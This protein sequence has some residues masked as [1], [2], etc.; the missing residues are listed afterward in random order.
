MDLMPVSAADHLPV[1][2][3][4]SRG[5]GICPKHGYIRGL[6]VLPLVRGCNR[7]R[8]GDE[9]GDRAGVE[10]GIKTEI[11]IESRWG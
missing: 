4:C 11:R 1:T 9:T 8:D 3:H 10:E 2:G 6:L 5:H 7:D